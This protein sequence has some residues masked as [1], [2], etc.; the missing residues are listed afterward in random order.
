M[1]ITNVYEAKTQFSKLLERVEKGEVVVIGRSGKPIAKLVPYEEP[2]P[3]GRAVSG[4]AKCG[5]PLT[6]TSCRP[7]S[8]TRS[9]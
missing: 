1:D 9:A 4:R 7:T 3:P 2:F 8:P 6:S 5:S